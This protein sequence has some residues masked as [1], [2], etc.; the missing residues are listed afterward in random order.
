MTDYA[1]QGK[2]RPYNIV[3][4]NNYRDHQ[5]HYTCLSRSATADGTIIL[6]EFDSTKITSGAHGTL[7]QEF[8]ELEI[9]DL[10]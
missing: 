10:I 2:T 6:Q 5:S 4:L 8:H 1:T 9:L 3:E 7:W